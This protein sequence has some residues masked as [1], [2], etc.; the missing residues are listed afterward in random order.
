MVVT[1]I[2]TKCLEPWYTNL[3]ICWVEIVPE[4]RKLKGVAR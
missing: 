3:S 4:Y 2:L 1:V